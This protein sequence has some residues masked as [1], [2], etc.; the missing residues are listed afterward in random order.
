VAERGVVLDEH[1]V[2]G[3]ARVEAGVVVVLHLKPQLF[4]FGQSRAHELFG[5]SGAL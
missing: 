3:V 5:L 1:H 4:Q 2:Q